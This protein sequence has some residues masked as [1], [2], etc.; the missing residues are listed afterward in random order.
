MKMSRSVFSSIVTPYIPT[1]P[2][3]EFERPRPHPA[4]RRAKNAATLPQQPAAAENERRGKA[5]SIAKS[6]TGEIAARGP[7]HSSNG[8]GHPAPNARLPTEA[9]VTGRGALAD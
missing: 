8:K 5:S 4:A 3:H 2:K 1:L 7:A 6:N 9:G